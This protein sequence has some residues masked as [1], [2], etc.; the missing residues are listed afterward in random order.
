MLAITTL[1]SPKDPTQVSG[2]LSVIVEAAANLRLYPKRHLYRDQNSFVYQ[3]MGA[4][5]STQSQSSSGG[6]SGG[7]FS[8]SESS[9]SRQTTANSKD[10][11]SDITSTI[12][13]VATAVVVTALL[14]GDAG[15]SGYSG[16]LQE[17]EGT[18]AIIS[19][20]HQLR[21]LC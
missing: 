15:D 6:S 20:E 14:G 13:G 10:D 12:A 5:Q 18:I 2:A 21:I 1:L 17:E 9:N 3:I 7:S 8:R 11:S 19:A 4:E 16:R